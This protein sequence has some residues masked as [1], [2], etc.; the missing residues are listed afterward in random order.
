MILDLRFKI[1]GT[2]CLVDSYDENIE[3][4]ILVRKIIIVVCFMKC[5]M[6]IVQ[7]MEKDELLIWLQILKILLHIPKINL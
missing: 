1:D 5:I 3:L 2:F 4:V 7:Y 6:N